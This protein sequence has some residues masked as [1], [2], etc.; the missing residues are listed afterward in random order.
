MTVGKDWV[1]ANKA[2]AKRS[3]AKLN[4]GLPAKLNFCAH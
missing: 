3:S 2:W 4:A 1:A